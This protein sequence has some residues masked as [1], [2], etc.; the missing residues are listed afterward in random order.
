VAQSAPPPGDTVTRWNLTLIAGLEAAA[1]PPPI[2]ARIAA[3]VQASVFDAVIGIARHFTPYHVAPD[4]PRG[5]SRDAAASEAAYTAM[6]ELLPAQQAIFDA[7]LS[8]SLAQNSDDP[9]QPGPAVGQGL[10]WGHTVAE[11][12][13]TWRATEGV[14]TVV[15]PTWRAPPPETDNPPHRNC[16]PPSSASSPTCHPSA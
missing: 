6:V 11:D 10:H 12:I 3:I 4:A 13:L 14:N 5:A 1:S 9:N 8:A 7:Q 2:A 16:C 15:P